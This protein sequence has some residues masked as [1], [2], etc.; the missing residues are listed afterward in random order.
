MLPYYAGWT[1]GPGNIKSLVSQ[2]DRWQRVINETAW[3][4]RHMFFNPKYKWM[5]MLTLPY[6]LLYEVMGVFVEII[7]ISVVAIAWVVGILDLRTFL[8]Y[9]CFMLLCEALVS[10]TSIFAL[11]RDQKVF[12]LKYVLYLVFLSLV[13]LFWYTW[14]ISF[15]RSL[16]TLRSFL[17]YRG[18]D[19]YVRE[20]RV[21]TS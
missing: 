18:Y 11:I 8:A 6:F 20:K 15:S 14:I 1:E 4:Y 13:E 10:I 2:R 5:G 12:R 19:Q 3:G 16:G 21:K 17:R 9:F 7:S